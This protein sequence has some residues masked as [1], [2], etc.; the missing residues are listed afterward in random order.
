VGQKDDN[1]D[2]G[3]YQGDILHDAQFNWPEAVC[4]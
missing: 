4:Q 1:A 2:E 3:Y